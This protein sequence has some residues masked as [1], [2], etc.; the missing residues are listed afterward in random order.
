MS[1]HSNVG[2]SSAPRWMACPGSVKACA[3]W[4][5]KYGRK[6][7][8]EFAAEGTAAHSLCELGLNKGMRA[9]EQ[10]EG[11]TIQ[12]EDFEIDVT[13]EMIDAVRIYVDKIF[14]DLEELGLD[15]SAL[16]VE[17]KFTLDHI[18]KELYGRNDACIYE[19]FGILKVYDFKYGAGIP[20]DVEDNKQLLYYA[21]GAAKGKDVSE[22]ELVVIQPR[23]R[24]A[25]GPIR[26]WRTSPEY[27]E[28]FEDTLKWKLA[29][30]REKN[31]E[32]VTG[33]YCRFCD[34]K[35]ECTQIKATT[36]EIAQTDF[37]KVPPAN[38]AGL[39]QEELIKVLKYSDIIKD[40]IKDVNTHAFDLLKQGV[41]L[42]GY[43][44]VKKKANRKWTNEEEVVAEFEDLYEDEIFVPR[45][46]K[47]PA[48]MEKIVGKKNVVDLCE[49]PEA[50]MVIAP[51]SDKREAVK[52]SA[53]E[54]FS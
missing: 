25:D 28:K 52:S 19:P 13:E 14:S 2:A 47:S 9:V 8:S 23:A 24:H 54:D 45:K 43:K 3:E 21:S 26:S 10:R 22:I 7:T 11:D 38:P 30:T 48:Q 27:L 36:M 49:I 4:I 34:A 50:G 35:P 12:V 40:W 41:E 39:T 53:I 46:I 32:L 31:A 15:G 20:V 37:D 6:P 44:L 1:E 33:A 16:S 42:P 29:N 5:K 17:Q 51:D 18:D